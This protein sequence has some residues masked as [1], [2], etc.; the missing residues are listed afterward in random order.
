MKFK[1]TLISRWMFVFFLIS[2]SNLSA[3]EGLNKLI[4]KKNC[5]VLDKELRYIIEKDGK[6]GFING[7][8]QIKTSPIFEAVRNYSEDV[9]LVKEKGFYGYLNKEGETII[10]PSFDYARSFNEGVAAVRINW[11]W[12]D[13]WGY[14]NKRGNFIKK[15]EYVFASSFYNGI[16]L[17]F[18]GKNIY[19]IDKKF[20]KIESFQSTNV[21][22]SI[23]P[24][25]FKKNSLKQCYYDYSGQEICDWDFD[26]R[27]SCKGKVIVDKKK[28]LDFFDFTGNELKKIGQIKYTCM[29]R[30]CLEKNAEISNDYIVVN[31]EN[32]KEGL[33]DFS[34]KIIVEP[35]FDRVLQVSDSSFAALENEKW[36]VFDKK[37][38]DVLKKQYTKVSFCKNEYS[39]LTTKKDG[40]K[41][42]EIMD[43]SFKPIFQG[44]F[45][46]NCTE[47]NR[48]IYRKDKKVFLYDLKSKS[49]LYSIDGN[50]IKKKKFG[51]MQLHDNTL[52]IT[53][54]IGKNSSLEVVDLISKKLLLYLK[55]AGVVDYFDT[56]NGEIIILKQ[57]KKIY[58]LDKN[59]M[60]IW[61]HKKLRSK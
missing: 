11:G 41:I 9:A 31:S 6:Y 28:G 38:K 25:Y 53:R 12:G 36:S 48:I 44:N 8:G 24:Q 27:F 7:C 49:I 47:N 33:S 19:L 26:K 52:I 13:V 43:T 18:D 10:P 56:P 5:S 20:S 37:G 23:S 54:G 59:F 17:V 50:D 40:K 30:F 42:T 34:G 22:F 15:P 35:V 1:A 32:L 4:F 16:A 14:I 58:Y 51:Q 2:Y 46:A 61:T 60:V 57:N 3:G 29:E 21:G 55:P 45:T 39:V